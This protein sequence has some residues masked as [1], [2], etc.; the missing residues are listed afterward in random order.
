MTLQELR[1]SD[2]FKNYTVTLDNGIIINY[3]S[4]LDGGGTELI[5]DYLKIFNILNKKYKNA[6]EWCSG[7]GILGFKILGNGIAENIHFSDIYQPAI[8]GKSIIDKFNPF[9]KQ[10]VSF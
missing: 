9:T 3:P 7:F 1:D 2:R 6:F 5:D 10:S 8:T 4:T